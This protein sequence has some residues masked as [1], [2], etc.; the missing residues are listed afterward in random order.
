MK[1]LMFFL[2]FLTYTLKKYNFFENY[3]FLSIE[4]QLYFYFSWKDLRCAFG[5]E[6]LREF[7]SPNKK[8]QKGN[9]YQR[10]SI[11]GSFSFSD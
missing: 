10:R 4:V 2:T 7:I 5:F 9:I 6:N 8:K 1:K 11:M 3:D